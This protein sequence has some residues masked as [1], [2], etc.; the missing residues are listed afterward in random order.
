MKR[1]RQIHD[2]ISIVSGS[3]AVK[4]SRARRVTKEHNTGKTGTVLYGYSMGLGIEHSVRS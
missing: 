1:A 4:V 2:G 3:A